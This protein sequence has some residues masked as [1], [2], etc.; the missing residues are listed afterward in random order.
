MRSA[1][2]TTTTAP[3]STSRSGMLLKGAGLL[4]LAALVLAFPSMAPDP[5]ILSVGVVIM[6]YAVLATS[7]NFVGGFTGYISLGHNVF[8]GIGGYGVGIAMAKLG[9][10]KVVV[11]YSGD[12][13]TTAKK[14][15]LRV[16][17]T[18]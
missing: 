15:V 16:N 5:F 11:K 17:V 8:F 6:S 18:R 2:D 7:W 4:V 13:L 12:E 1:S 14:K 10:N 9:K 3:G